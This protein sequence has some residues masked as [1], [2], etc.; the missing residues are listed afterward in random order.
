MNILVIEDNRQERVLLRAALSTVPGVS[1][2][3]VEEADRLAAAVSCL[4]A[5]RFDAILLDL[6]LPD[7]AGLDTLAH[8]QA[9]APEAPIVILTGMDD[10]RLTM[11]GLRRGAQDYLVKGR[12]EGPQLYRALRHAMERKRLVV[13][14]EARVAERTVELEAANHTLQR[15]LAERKRT[16]EKLR[17]AKFTIAQASDA[18]YWIDPQARIMDVNRAACAMLGYSKKELCALTVHDLNPDFRADMWPAFWADT[19]TRATVVIE[20]RHRARNGQMI[21]VEVAVNYLQSDGKEYHCA[22]VRDITVR[23][24][25]EEEI[26][27]AHAFLDSIVENI[28]H[29]IFVKDATDLRFV[30]FNKAGEELLGYSRQELIGKNDHELFPK[31]EAEFFVSNDRAVLDSNQLL[32]IPDERIQ[33]KHHGARFL[34]TKKIPLLDQEGRPQYL[35]GISEDITERKEAEQKRLEQEL[36]ITLMGTSK[37]SNI[38]Q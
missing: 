10:E 38:D 12:Y 1:I 23:R 32:D 36:L 9:R 34:H 18:I 14:L 5:E 28:P 2:R 33:T 25:A 29:M 7:S 19:R 31:A 3:R 27:R 6:N 15:D 30:R 13:E 11:E 17:I 21:P 22:F 4:T 8:V 26:Q 20:T 24:Q 37:N 16:D 35:L